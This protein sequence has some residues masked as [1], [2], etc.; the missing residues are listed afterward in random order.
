MGA[1]DMQITGGSSV[2][3]VVPTG[4]RLNGRWH[5]ILSERYTRRA[6]YMDPKKL[7]IPMA[8]IFKGKKSRSIQTKEKHVHIRQD[9]PSQRKTYC[10]TRKRKA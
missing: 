6:I 10:C 4:S 7:E 3:A 5:I 9:T 1:A 8:N 2:R